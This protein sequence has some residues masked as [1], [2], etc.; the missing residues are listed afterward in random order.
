MIRRLFFAPRVVV[1]VSTIGISGLALA[2][3]TAYPEIT[4]FSATYPPAVDTTWSDV[5]GVRVTG[6]QLAVL[7]VVPI[8]ALALGWF[9][10]RTLVGRTVKASAEN[11]DL[12]RV[13]GINP[14]I[15]V[16][17]G[18]VDRRVPGHAHD[19][20]GGGRQ[21]RRGEGPPHARTEHAGARAGGGGHRGHG[22][23]PAGDGRGHRDRRRR[24]R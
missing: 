23:V 9:L 8:V 21:R 24:R 10:N 12:A 13:Q 14:K 18:V 7:V 19:D 6:A 5:L 11:P 2:I 17:R 15:G 16:H 20:A 1:L 4:D 3:V 22:V